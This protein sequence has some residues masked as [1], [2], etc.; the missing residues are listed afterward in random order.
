MNPM[1][2][3]YNRQGQPIDA[4]TA[5]KLLG[6]QEYARVALTEITSAT[7]P[8]IHYRV[9]TVW[10]GVNHNFAGDGPPILFE[11]MSFGGDGDQDQTQWRWGTEAEAL[12]GHAEVVA[13]I[14]ATVPDERVQ[15]TVA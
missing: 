3:W 1:Q 12:A 11:T 10:L 14:A 8:A 2:I 13:T 9:S 6:D 7:D 5:D 15:H 4:V